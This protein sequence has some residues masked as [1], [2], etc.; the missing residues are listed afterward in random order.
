MPE[1]HPLVAA[2]FA[3]TPVEWKLLLTAFNGF[4]LGL[5]ACQAV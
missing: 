1:T 4:L 5:L 3:L 2:P